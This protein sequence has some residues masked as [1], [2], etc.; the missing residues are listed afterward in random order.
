VPFYAYSVAYGSVPIFIPPWW[1]HSWYNTRYGL[2]LLPAFALGLGGAARL[3]LAL[4]RIFKPRWVAAAVAALSALIGLNSW[5]V[6]REHPLVYIEGT[7]NYAARRH[8][9]EVIPAALRALLTTRSGGIVLMDTSVYPQIVALTGIPLRQTINESDKEFYRDALAA[10]AAHA[11]IV[12]AF[13]DDEV[14]QAV[15]AH[16]AGLREVRRFSAPGQ[17]TGTLY[18]SDTPISTTA[19]AR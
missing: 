3:A 1:P 19:P 2:E 7:K 17:P 10:P 6:L 4:V 5:Q 9:E 8:Y 16:P 11:A 18:V 14:S 12:L 13:D 15:A